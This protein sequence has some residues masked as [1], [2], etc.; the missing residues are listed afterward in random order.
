LFRLGLTG[1]R[2]IKIH[3]YDDGLLQI[4]EQILLMLINN[5]HNFLSPFKFLRQVCSEVESTGIRDDTIGSVFYTLIST[6]SCIRKKVSILASSSTNHQYAYLYV[7]C[8]PTYHIRV[9]VQ[10]PDARYR[11]VA[12]ADTESYLRYL[13]NKMQYLGVGGSQPFL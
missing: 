6:C 1:G 10:K 5:S 9:S 3:I 11:H 2:H 12:E 13:C 8:F 7:P 4:A